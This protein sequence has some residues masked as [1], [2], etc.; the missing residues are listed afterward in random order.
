VHAI[1]LLHVTLK[2]NNV[3]ID[4]AIP[5]RIADFSS[6]RLQQSGWQASRRA[7]EQ[8]SGTV[9]GEM[10]SRFELNK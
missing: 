8:A 10:D 6:M 2:A 1:R 9:R 7:G 4:H 3:L 5:V